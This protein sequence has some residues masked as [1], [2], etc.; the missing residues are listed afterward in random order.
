MNDTEFHAND[1]SPGLVRNLSFYEILD[2]PVD[3]SE[4]DIDHAF[5]TFLQEPEADSRLKSQRIHAWEVLRDPLNRSYYDEYL[6]K[7]RFAEVRSLDTS[8]R[9]GLGSMSTFTLGSSDSTTT[10]ASSKGRRG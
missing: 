9:K 4:V 7:Q 3:A 6:A 5:A 2:V 1:S 8:G 10:K